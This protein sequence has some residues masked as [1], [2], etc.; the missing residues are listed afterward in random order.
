MASS[1]SSSLDHLLG[2]VRVRVVR[3][4]NLA[5]RDV[6]SS[7][8][9]VVVKLGKQV[10]HTKPP[11][12]T[13]TF[14]YMYIYQTLGFFSLGRTKYWFLQGPNHCGVIKRMKLSSI[15]VIMGGE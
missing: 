10:P 4:V 3:G 1:G 13:K 7:D 9:Y 14:I 8:P 12:R 5:V 2:L 15:D 11:T 6:R